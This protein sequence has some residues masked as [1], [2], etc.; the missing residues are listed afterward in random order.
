MNLA[1]MNQCTS[2][3]R[4][5]STRNKEKGERNK[6]AVVMDRDEEGKQYESGTRGGQIATRAEGATSRD[7]HWVK[8]VAQSRA[9][10]AQ[11]GDREDVSL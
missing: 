8:R 7:D 3:S 5:L 1:K 6:I 2:R 11:S 4:H 10:V 9:E